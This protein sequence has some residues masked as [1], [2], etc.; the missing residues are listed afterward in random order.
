MTEKEIEEIL[1]VKL[2]KK[3]SKRYENFNKKL[4]LFREKVN[5]TETLEIYFLKELTTTSKVIEKNLEYI[6]ICNK[7]LEDIKDDLEWFIKNKIQDK[8]NEIEEVYSFRTML[9][10]MCR[11]FEFKKEVEE[12][13]NNLKIKEVKQLI[14]EI[15]KNKE[16][17]KKSEDI[18]SGFE[19]EILKRIGEIVSVSVNKTLLEKYGPEIFQKFDE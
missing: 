9:V 1:G 4:K 5:L 17:K 2:D 13:N 3:I 14:S 16:I 10:F 12:G 19:E 11:A 6:E 7:F 15:K 8:I 18:T